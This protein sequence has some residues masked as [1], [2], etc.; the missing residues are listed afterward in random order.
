[1]RSMVCGVTGFGVR[2]TAKGMVPGHICIVHVS[3]TQVSKD[4][5]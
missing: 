2:D 4:I 3:F 5:A 1:M